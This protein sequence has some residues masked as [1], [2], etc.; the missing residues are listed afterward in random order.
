MKIIETFIDLYEKTKKREP[1]KPNYSLN[2][3]EKRTLPE[4]RDYFEYWCTYSGQRLNY[5]IKYLMSLRPDINN[6]VITRVTFDY[7]LIELIEY[8]P[9]KTFIYYVM[10][11]ILEEVKK[12][13]NLIIY[14]E[15]HPIRD[16]KIKYRSSIIYMELFSFCKDGVDFSDWQK[17]L[18]WDVQ[19]HKKIIE[20]IRPPLWSV[21]IPKG[22]YAN[23]TYLKGEIII[24]VWSRPDRSFLYLIGT[25]IE[26]KE[27][28]LQEITEKYEHFNT[29]VRPIIHK[30]N[31]SGPG[32]DYCWDCW[33]S[34]YINEK[35]NKAFSLSFAKP[36]KFAGI[37]IRPH[38]MDK[39]ETDYIKKF[40]IHSN[41]TVFRDQQLYA[42]YQFIL[43]SSETGR[44][45][46]AFHCETVYKQLGLSLPYL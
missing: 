20:E 32:I 38:G 23:I 33:A 7:E 43:S 30:H 42:A 12:Y 13:K 4:K 21:I 34:I 16:M 6:I 19:L 35:F 39:N 46:Y 31:K 41:Y 2:L 40:I 17:T 15:F 24:P 29:F 1:Q 14:N 3:G 18:T 37:N 44:L 28:N 25:D 27:Y 10:S 22:L 5:A 36:L 9:E 11:P 45:N 8:F 26:D